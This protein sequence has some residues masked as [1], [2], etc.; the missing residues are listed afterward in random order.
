ML[1]LYYVHIVHANIF[2]S[3][4][5]QTCCSHMTV[6]VECLI[7]HNDRGMYASENE[8]TGAMGSQCHHGG[9]IASGALLTLSGGLICAV[10]LTLNHIPALF[11]QFLHRQ[12][13]GM[14]VCVM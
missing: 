4:N 14:C 9:T 1:P 5:I 13:L 7:T 12:L 6:C 3:M 8:E 11:D 2:K 10:S